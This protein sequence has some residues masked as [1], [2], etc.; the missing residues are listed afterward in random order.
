[1][2]S[3]GHRSRRQEDTD[4]GY[5]GSGPQRSVEGWIVFVTGVHEEAQED[6]EFCGVDVAFA[7]AMSFTSYLH[8]SCEYFLQI[9]W[10]RSPSMAK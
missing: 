3:S 5:T 1:M 8:C 4:T 9:S 7:M 10:M 6:G 2:S